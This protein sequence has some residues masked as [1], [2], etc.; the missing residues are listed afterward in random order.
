MTLEAIKILKM[1][2]RF[3]I[4]TDEV[5]QATAEQEATEKFKKKTAATFLQTQFASVIRKKEEPK[6]KTEVEKLVDICVR[7]LEYDQFYAETLQHLKVVRKY[8]E[9]R[10]NRNLINLNLKFIG[11]GSA[12]AGLDWTGLMPASS[13]YKPPRVRVRRRE[14]PVRLLAERGG[15]REREEGGESEEETA[16]FAGHRL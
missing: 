3:G 9:I 4:F 16:D 1:M 12:W 6:I 13:R 8:E 10:N 11:N 5:A 7:I 15:Q 14:G 2:L